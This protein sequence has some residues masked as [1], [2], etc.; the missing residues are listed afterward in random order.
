MR[1]IATIAC[2]LLLAAACKNQTDAPAAPEPPKAKAPPAAETPEAAPEPEKP[3]SEVATF[4]VPDMD[5]ALVKSLVDALAGEKGIVSAKPDTDA[6]TLHVT[7]EPG[8]TNP[9]TIGKV[10]STVS[11]GAQLEKVAAST[12]P[13]QPA[14]DCGGC[15]MH[16]TCGGKH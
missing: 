4:S 3:A 8:T 1:R 7:F 9:S 6:G 15:P 10:L 5:A 12:D 16:D 14:H 2:A 13:A 11:A